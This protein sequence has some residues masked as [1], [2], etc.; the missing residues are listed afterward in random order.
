MQ[1]IHAS[2]RKVMEA[3]T[4]TVAIVLA[5]RNDRAETKAAIVEEQLAGLSHKPLEQAPLRLGGANVLVVRIARYTRQALTHGLSVDPTLLMP[6]HHPVLL[7]PNVKKRI[8]LHVRINLVGVAVLIVLVL[9]ERIIIIIV[10]AVR[11]RTVL[12]MRLT[13]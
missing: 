8:K 12:R 9:H 1:Q 11:T 3:E 6:R 7:V 13:L 2:I 10:P 4:T 5:R